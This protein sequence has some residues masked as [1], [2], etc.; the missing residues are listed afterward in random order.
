[1][2]W[3]DDGGVEFRIHVVSRR[4]QAGNPL[5]RLGLRLVG[6]REQ[7]RFARRACKRMDELVVRELA[8]AHSAAAQR[9]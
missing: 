5:I 6:R 9:A 1:M 8:G 3:L 2:K 4:A 7:V